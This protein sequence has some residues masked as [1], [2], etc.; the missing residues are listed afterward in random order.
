VRTAAPSW[1]CG[2]NLSPA[3]SMRIRIEKPFGE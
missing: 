1:N 2:E 3:I